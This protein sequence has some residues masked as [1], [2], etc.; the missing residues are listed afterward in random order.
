MAGDAMLISSILLHSTILS[1]HSYEGNM[2]DE[3]VLKL[4]ITPH[5]KISIDKEDG[6]DPGVWKLC[7]DYRALARIEDAIG[8][9]LKKIADWNNISSGQHFPK[10]IWGALQRFNPE[11]TLEQVLD[12]LNP[13]AQRILSDKLFEL[14]FP[15]AKE[16]YQKILDEQGTGATADPNA[17]TVQPTA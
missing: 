17:P 14:C 16:A 15:G 8:L 9:D 2:K 5:F 10:I 6:T 13:E 1:I 4:A 11:V 7:L 3:T 12:S